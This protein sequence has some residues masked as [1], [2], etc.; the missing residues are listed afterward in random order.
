[1][2]HHKTR[3]ATKENQLKHAKKWIKDL[4]YRLQNSTHGSI[5]YFGRQ[6]LTLQESL[7]LDQLKK[8]KIKVKE[9]ETELNG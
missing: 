8:L 4:E 6:K 3:I 5:G 7:D 2:S 9:L 1:M